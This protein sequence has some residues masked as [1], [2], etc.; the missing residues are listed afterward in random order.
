M[1]NIPTTTR[2]LPQ[3]KPEAVGFTPTSIWPYGVPS[4]LEDPVHGGSHGGASP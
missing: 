2:P 3:D 4:A 1:G